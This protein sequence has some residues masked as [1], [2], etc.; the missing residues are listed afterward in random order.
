[1]AGRSACDRARRLSLSLE[2]AVGRAR[3][4]CDGVRWQSSTL[5]SRARKEEQHGPK[6][7]QR[8]AAWLGRVCSAGTLKVTVA[9]LSTVC[10]H[11]VRPVETSG[12]LRFFRSRWCFGAGHLSNR[13][14]R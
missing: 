2:T 14:R 13:T 1:M 11:A 8:S 6:A 12:Q 3:A 4:G 5:C 10:I 9:V 7:C